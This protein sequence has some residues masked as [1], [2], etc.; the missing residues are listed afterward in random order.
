MSP[1]RR[2]IP[3][4][5][6]VVAAAC[7]EAAGPV[8]P[9][10]PDV[11]DLPD[12]PVDTVPVVPGTPNTSDAIN[13]LVG[14][15]PRFEEA[16]VY[17]NVTPAGVDTT[18]ETR[19][20]PD[21]AVETTYFQCVVER[22]SVSDN[23]QDFMMYDPLASVL[24][25]GNL[26]QGNSIV[27]GVPNSIPI[28]DRASGNI[29]LAI[30]SGGE[31]AAPRTRQLDD[32][33]FS[34]VNAAMNEILSDY[35]GGTP[36]KYSFSMQRVYSASHLEFGLDVGYSGPAF[37]MSAEL[38]ID[39]SEEKSRLVV[40]LTQK[41]FTMVFDDPEGPS[42][43]FRD[44]F[45]PDRLAPYTGPGNPVTYISS[46]TYGRIYYLLFESSLSH[47]E[48]ETA[49]NLAYSG[50]VVSGDLDAK[51]TFDAVMEQTS[52][53]AWQI[54]GD[55][56]AG[57]NAADPQSF[58]DWGSIKDFVSQGANF[59][60]TNIGEPISYTIKYLN[61]A[62]LVRMNNTTEYEVTQCAPYATDTAIPVSSVRF[63]VER[64][65]VLESASSKLFPGDGGIALEV[66]STD[67]TTGIH[68]QRY[69]SPANQDG[70]A[71][72]GLVSNG[73]YGGQTWDLGWTVP[74]F[75]LEQSTDRAIRLQV[76]G[77]EWYP[78]I[79]QGVFAAG[80]SI[81]TF[82][83]D[84]IQGGWVRDDGVPVTPTSTYVDVTIGG[85][86]NTKLRIHYKLTV[87]EVVPD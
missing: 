21:G 53:R 46:V 16:S 84:P 49:L 63:Q 32:F 45:D 13:E 19:T 50:G 55:P 83:F 29:T 47:Q 15:V 60:A 64:V 30:V 86:W 25:P 74:A 17:A 1:I 14:S 35:T 51:S 24:W 42:G 18:T 67:K 9:A 65:E 57:L 87:E 52:V 48:I 58:S 78:G 59:S 71:W 82:D 2:L 81:V 61:D 56:E 66:L 37:D 38:G 79:P 73:F 44:G 6:A 23:P 3:F 20:L 70:R 22:H 69:Q 62:S 68:T 75:E 77:I 28:A 43:V 10:V 33:R 7:S 41:F 8:A 4:L 72:Y 5:L 54:G 36:A 85:D 39:W 80:T 31:D 34:T 27:G 26:V 11:P 12:P 76:W 40:K